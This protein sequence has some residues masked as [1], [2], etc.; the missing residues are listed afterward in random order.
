M[1]DRFNPSNDEW[2]LKPNG[3]GK[4]SPFAYVPFLG[5]SRVCLGKTFAEVTLRFTIPLWF[6]FFDFDFTVEE[7]RKERPVVVL[8]SVK[9]IEIPLKMT[10]RNKVADLPNF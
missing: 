10:T 8:G 6:H 9:A 7:H 4:R 1:P 5:G 3:G 2:Y